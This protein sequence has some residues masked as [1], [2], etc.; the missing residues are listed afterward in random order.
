MPSNPLFGAAGNGHVDILQLLLEHG[1]D[2]NVVESTYS[3]AY[4]SVLAWAARNGE[5][6][7][8]KF[9]LANGV[10]LKSYYN[11]PSALKQAAERGHKVIAADHKRAFLRIS[12][13]DVKETEQQSHQTINQ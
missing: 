1:A 7:M 3:G 6:P 8:V 9:L 11:G 10:D 5:T 12:Q 4:Y 13:K 2:V